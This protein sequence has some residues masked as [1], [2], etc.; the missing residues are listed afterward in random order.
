MTCLFKASSG[1]CWMPLIEYIYIYI[2]CVM[3]ID[4]L[5]WP[6]QQGSSTCAGMEKM[7]K[8]MVDLGMKKARAHITFELMRALIM[9]RGLE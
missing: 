4:R 6:V 5:C 8:M 2:I 9:L 7:Q 3:K 1:S